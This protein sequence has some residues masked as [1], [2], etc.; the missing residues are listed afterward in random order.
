MGL[1]ILILAF[2]MVPGLAQQGTTKAPSS[3]APPQRTT[4]TPAKKAS[5]AKPAA[6]APVP[7][8]PEMV[9]ARQKKACAA[10]DFKVCLQLRDLVEAKPELRPPGAAV[11]DSVPIGAGYPELAVGTTWTYRVLSL[12]SALDNK[13]LDIKLEQASAAKATFRVRLDGKEQQIEVKH[14]TGAKY[15]SPRAGKLGKI[16]LVAEETLPDNCS[17]STQWSASPMRRGIIQGGQVVG[18]VNEGPGRSASGPVLHK[19]PG[20]TFPAAVLWEDDTRMIISPNSAFVAQVLTAIPDGARVLFDLVSVKPPGAAEQTAA[21]ALESAAWNKLLLWMKENTLAGDFERS[22]VYT[23]V[24]HANQRPEM[25]FVMIGG[26]R[27]SKAGDGVC[28][29]W[30][31]DGLLTRNCDAQALT[32]EPNRSISFAIP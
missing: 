9:L 22:M 15:F 5:P 11:P 7:E 26:A 14:K 18:W 32:V 16:E 21:P 13:L 2:S 20:G 24:S 23:L 30:G 27:L 12:D 3:K 6:P 10:G 29:L 17:K 4:R 28:L 31:H 1:A 25:Q 8:T 19:L